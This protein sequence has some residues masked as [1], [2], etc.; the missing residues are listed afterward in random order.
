MSRFTLFFVKGIG[1]RGDKMKKHLFLIITLMYVVIMLLDFLRL[2][3]P[4]NIIKIV[5]VGI[6]FIC[7]IIQ[8]AT[9]KK[10]F[11]Q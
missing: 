2:I 1:K 10:T 6:Y 9:A 5:L 8:I 4:G 3:H 11:K 7:A